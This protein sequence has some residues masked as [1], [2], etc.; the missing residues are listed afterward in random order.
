MSSSKREIVQKA[1]E[2]WNTG[3]VDL[4]DEIYAPEL[5]YHF[6]PV[7]EMDLAGLKQY[8]AGVLLGIPDF[9]V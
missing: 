4:L 8:V 2:G 5:T 9:K 7:A 6:P 3:K 1:Y